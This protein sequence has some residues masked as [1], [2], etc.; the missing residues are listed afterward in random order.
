MFLSAGQYFYKVCLKNISIYELWFVEEEEE[1]DNN[2]KVAT[3]RCAVSHWVGS[4]VGQEY[5]NW[6]D[7]WGS[8]EA[9]ERPVSLFCLLHNHF[10]TMAAFDVC[11]AFP[12]LT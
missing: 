12:R 11:F 3:E 1:I 7:I 5:F 9:K 4:C 6:G 2:Q 10:S 8:K